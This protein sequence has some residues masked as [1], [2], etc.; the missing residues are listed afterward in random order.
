MNTLLIKNTRTLL[1]PNLPVLTANKCTKVVTKHFINTPL[2]MSLDQCSLFQWLLYQSGAD[3]TFIYNTQLLRSYSK[4]IGEAQKEYG[5]KNG[6]KTS[7]GASR[8]NLTYLLTNGYIL[9]LNEFKMIIN[10]MF[11]YYEFISR[12]EYVAFCNKYQLADVNNIQPLLAE[13]VNMVKN[14]M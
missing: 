6:L 13:Y 3:N 5:G 10:P 9:W 1:L 14:K 4:S 2:Y 8:A 7:L 11:T 12:R